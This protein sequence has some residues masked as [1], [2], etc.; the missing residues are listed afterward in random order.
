MANVISSNNLTSL[1]GTGTANVVITAP[2]VPNVPNTIQSKNL[3]TLYSSGGNPV[4]AVGSYGNSNVAS[5]LNVGTDGA[6]TI[7]NIV[8]TGNVTANYYFGNGYYLTGVGNASNA[9][10]ANYAYYA[11]NVTINAQPNITSLGTLTQLKVNGISNLG[12]IGNVHITGG[13]ANY[14]L[15]TDGNGNLSWGQVANASNAANANYAN[16]AG[17]AFSVNV[18]NVV[19]IGNIAVLN[20]DGNSGNILYGNGVFSAVP[21]TAYSNNSNYANYAGNLIHGFSNVTI[22]VANGNIYINANN[23]TDQQ[24]IF[25]NDSNLTT[26]GNI[27]MGGGVIR[28][29]NNSGLELSSSNRV[30]MNH[31]DVDQ[32]TAS[33]SGVD[34]ITREGNV[35]LQTYYNRY[36]WNFDNTGNTQ[37]PANSIGNLGYVVNANYFVGDGS[38][39]SNI[40]AG[41]ISGTVANANYSAYANQANTAN[42]ATFATTANSVAGANVSGVV[43]NANYAAYAG[44][45][46]NTVANANFAAY[47]GNV[48]V[49]AQ[50]NITTVG[51]L[52]NLNI[53]NATSNS[54]QFLF[55]PNGTNVGLAGQNTSSFVI[56]QFNTQPG[57]S[58]QVLNMTFTAA[59]GNAT[60]PSN[61]ANSDYIGRMGW[62]T[63]NTNTYVRN[64]LI[65][66][67]APQGGNTTQQANNVAWASGSF[68]INTGHPF[69]N[70]TS[71][72]ALS[73]QNLMGWNQYGTL[74]LSP[75]T[76]SQGN[77]TTGTAI[78]ITSYGANTDGAGQSGRITILRQRGN[79][80]GSVAV[81]NTDGVGAIT[82]SAYNGNG[83]PGPTGIYANVNT[84]SGSIANGVVV[85]I[86]LQ[87]VTGNTAS[88]TWTTTHS[89]NGNVSF[90]SGRAV[91]GGY[92]YGDGSNLSNITGGNVTGQVGN[93][94]VAGTVYTNAQPNITSVGTLTSLGV[95]GNITAANITANTGIFTGDGGGLSNINGANI[96]NIVANAN[97]A[98]YA[99]NVTIASQGNITTVGNLLTLNVIN[100]TS[101][102]TQF[103]FS[104]NGTNVGV[105]GQNTASFIINQ[106]TTQGGVGNQV[107]NMQFNAA[108]GNITNPA[109][110]ANSD[111]I[112]SMSW[113]SYNGNTYVRN[114]RITVLAPQGGDSSLSNAN[115]AWSA[116]SFFI[117]TGNPFGNVTSNTASSS[118]N[119]LQFNRYG[120]L[121]I[122]PGAPGPNAAAQTSLTLQGY[123]SNT[124][125][126]G[127]ITNRILFQRS[128]GNRDG[129]TA[130][131]NTDGVGALSFAGYNGSS[132]NGGITLNAIANTNGNSVTSGVPVPL[133]LVLTTQSSNSNTYTTT[134]FATGNVT[135]PVIGNVTA[136]NF[137]GN[138]TGLSNLNVPTLA[139]TATGG[140]LTL[141]TTGAGAPQLTINGDATS[142]SALNVYDAQ[143]A[144][145]MDGVS[146]LTGFSPFRFSV[147]NNTYSQTLPLRLF[148]A[149][150]TSPSPLPVQTND[151]VVDLNFAVYADSGNTYYNVGDLTYTVSSNDGAGNVTVNARLQGQQGFGIGSNLTLGFSNVTAD[152]NLYAGNNLG[153][154]N[155]ITGNTLNITS[156]ATFANA[157]VT[158]ANITTANITTANITTANIATEV[159]TGNANVANLQ[160]N[161]FQE[162]V[163]NYGNASG[164]ITPDFNNGSIQQLLLT[165]NI[166]LNSLGNALAGRSMTLILTQ[167]ST[168]GRTLTSSWLYASGTKT[169]SVSAGSVDIISVFYDGTTYY[170]SLTTGYA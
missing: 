94:L 76:Y 41:N 105:A 159:V 89:A 24:W 49:N 51:N 137:V 155:N 95:S 120:S 145:I 136:N 156:L 70:I 22:P 56:N 153:A 157:N 147:Y 27:G 59:R 14:A 80:D 2:N 18:A 74:S 139:N 100:A 13:N 17:N 97:F 121:L 64:A 50:G 151:Q 99:G 152:G 146:P 52:L 86:D 26:P 58:N 32:V 168:A 135:F 167:D 110:V 42:L 57:L 128:R 39:L 144:Y 4:A 43:A 12:N 108:R 84:V 40:T 6:N 116:G 61:V 150:G 143:S 3:T 93:A 124:D 47:A 118:Q 160:L 60:N 113:N 35:T 31:D 111:Y 29:L 154:I 130:I 79:R 166:T 106:F 8:A 78:S 161:R 30:T 75:G 72:T 53:I 104:P 122:Q 117:N 131:A 38:N 90:P 163:Y 92:F 63:W 7:N 33:S 28:D 15:I 158:I 133:D 142:N 123:G 81:A 103:L 91:I 36:I 69:G 87:I 114:A 165:G 101:N 21:N 125:G 115:V 67:L 9:T 23:G 170:A 54:T 83:S 148:R 138:G 10:T 48:T 5:F 20:L 45:V 73:S 37:F 134:F 11:G 126:A 109:N 119:I 162:T 82:F 68:F 19:G 149:R 25:G 88:N 140:R 46:T 98:A 65:T 129:A 34:L 77:G 127:G 132:Y 112:G 141:N 66:V 107:L 164:T 62:N 102:S 1:Y 96:T 85:P 169:L 44:N 16:F 55:T 71:N